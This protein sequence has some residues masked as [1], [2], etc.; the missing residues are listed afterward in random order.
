MCEL[1]LFTILGIPLK[2]TAV[3]YRAGVLVSLPM[4]VPDLLFRVLHSENGS[5]IDFARRNDEET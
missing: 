5:C 3:M 1:A 4:Q 2:C